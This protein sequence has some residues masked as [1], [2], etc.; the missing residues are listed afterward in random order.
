MKNICVLALLLGALGSARASFDLVLVTDETTNSVHRFDGTSGAYLGQFGK[1][2]LSLP[3]GVTVNPATS[4]A[5]VASYGTSSVQVY[6]YSTGLFVNEFSVGMLARSISWVGS[7]LLVSGGGGLRRYTTSGSLVTTFANTGTVTGC[8]VGTDG[9]VYAYNVSDG[10]F[11]RF[12]ASGVLTGFVGSATDVG[13]YPRYGA[14]KY[15]TQNIWL[16]NSASQIE[17]QNTPAMTMSSAFG[18]S[19]VLLYPIGIAPGHASALYVSGYSP[20]SGNPPI[21]AQVSA[22]TGRVGLT[23][24][25]GTLVQPRGM[26]SVVAPEPATWIALA[27]GALLV[28]RRRKRN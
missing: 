26:A 21:I 16:N 5:Y 22:L 24:G 10:Q 3:Q 8:T 20:A 27:F 13:S 1:G 25:A 7:D 9:L 19:A 12:A 17:F 14:I 11:Q 28:A 4:L 18:L 2:R 23:F 6:N 15:G